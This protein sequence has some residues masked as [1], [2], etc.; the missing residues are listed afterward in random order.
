MRGAPRSGAPLFIGED[1]VQDTLGAF[2]PGVSV[3]KA[4]RRAGP[5][6]GL[7]FA[8]K[9][10]FDVAGLVTGCGNPDWAAT[11]EPAES[12]AWAVNALLEA[13]AALTGKSITDEISLGLLGINRF[14]GTPL[15][16]RAPDRVAGG[17]SSGSASAVAGGLV[18]FSLGTDSGGSV[19][20]P[21]SFCGLYGLRPTHGRIPVA[22]MMTQAPSFDTVGFFAGNAKTFGEVGAV[23]F[24]EPVVDVLPDEIIVATDCFALA[25]EPVQ[26]ALLP[27]IA[28]LGAAVPVTK[29]PLAEGDV[30]AWSQHQRVLQRSEFQATFRDWIDR[31]N[32]R[33]SAEV[34]GAFADDG[35]INADELAAA[36]A[37]RGSAS[38]QLDA[39]LDGRRML[40]MPTSPI[41][42]IRR[43]AR[44]S[45]MRT[46][47]HRIVD[48][49]GIAGLTGLPQVNLPFAA[50]GSIPV[51]L[52]LI[53]WRGGDARLLGAAGALADALGAGSQ[54]EFQ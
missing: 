23:L 29:M 38:T 10:L 45:Q 9:D 42:P 30:L 27:L 25:D 12:D 14:H 24:G 16:P 48:L 3:N 20:I 49:T 44:L 13:G 51:G 33:F 43:D 54:Q 18:D 34:A 22:G 17:S 15:N 11:H 7:R 26:A 35:R 52:S 8:A 2:V 21:A 39:L 46:A 28:Q 37:F 40:C 6:S 47:V 1:T 19:R 5:L 4:P 31:V 50:S 53:G 41:L 36:A 32:P